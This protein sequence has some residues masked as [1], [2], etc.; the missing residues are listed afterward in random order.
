M[1]GKVV[2]IMIAN[3]SKS[4]SLAAGTK[5]PSRIY[6]AFGSSKELWR[7][8][9]FYKFCQWIDLVPVKEPIFFRIQLT[10]VNP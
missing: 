6:K 1:G 2:E 9:E 8:Y 10:L 5:I 4:G 7:T 3:D